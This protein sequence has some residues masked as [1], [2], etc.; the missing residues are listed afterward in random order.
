MHAAI[1]KGFS[2]NET[3][4]TGFVPN[5]TVSKEICVMNNAR[6]LFLSWNKRSVTNISEFVNCL[7]VGTHHCWQ[8]FIG[9]K[10][11]SQNGWEQ[12]YTFGQV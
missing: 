1:H 11:P 10:L 4:S 5:A 9:H 7:C 2:L 3:M 6:L 8:K 12:F